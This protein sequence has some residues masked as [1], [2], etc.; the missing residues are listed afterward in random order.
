MSANAM[1]KDTNDPNQ[2][3]GQEWGIYPP[4]PAARSSIVTPVSDQRPAAA[5][6]SSP[7]QCR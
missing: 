2:A 6:E 5:T 1:F 3:T 7:Q 4:E